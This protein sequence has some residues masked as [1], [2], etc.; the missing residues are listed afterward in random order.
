MVRRLKDSDIQNILGTLTANDIL[1]L[2][3]ER[4]SSL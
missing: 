3:R 1:Q 4:G 2:V